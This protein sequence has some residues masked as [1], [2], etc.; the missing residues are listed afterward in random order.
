MGLF[1]RSSSTTNNQTN[2]TSLNA[3]NSVGSGGAGV[4]FAGGNATIVTTDQGTVKASSYI[5]QSAIHAGESGFE[6]ANDTLRTLSGDA[7]DQSLATIDAAAANSKNVLDTAQSLSGDVLEAAKFSQQQVIDALTNQNQQ[8]LQAANDLS[9]RESQN[10]GGQLT[11][12]TQRAL[13][14]AGA[15]AAAALLFAI[16]RK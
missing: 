13:Y 4:G 15:V 14:V 12:I 8:F 6:V 16:F 7:K 1:D 11:A 3:G 5:A 10:T 2:N 9:T